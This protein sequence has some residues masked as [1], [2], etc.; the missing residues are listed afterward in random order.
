MQR[1]QNLLPLSAR[2]SIWAR[3]QPPLASTVV[4]PPHGR[5]TCARTD[6]AWTDVQT[7]QAGLVE[8][9]QKMSRWTVH[10]AGDLSF[11]ARPL[12]TGHRLS[13]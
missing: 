12:L 8:E 9:I 5:F 6:G 7:C 3:R 2:R 10:D 1:L 11:Q 13:P 4:L